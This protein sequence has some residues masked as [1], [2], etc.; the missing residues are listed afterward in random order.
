RLDAQEPAGDAA[1]LDQLR[2]YRPESVD[3]Y[4]KTQPL[5]SLEHERIDAHNLALSVQQRPTGVPGIDRRVRLQEIVELSAESC[6]TLR[7]EES[8]GDR[9]I[10]SERI[11]DGDDPLTHPQRIAVAQIG[12]RKRRSSWRDFE[13]SNVGRFVVTLD[14]RR[15]LT[16]IV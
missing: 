2:H 12:N 13:Q 11:A 6:S 16:A 5:C 3:R 10:Q 14:R 7:A 1:A 8:E 9:V 15:K 4:G